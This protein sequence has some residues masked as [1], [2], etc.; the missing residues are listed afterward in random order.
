M[1]EKTCATCEHF[2][3]HYTLKSGR[4][5]RIYCGHCTVA[6]PKTKRPT[7]RACEKYAYGHPDESAFAS[8]KYLTKEMVKYL[9]GMELL[10]TIEDDPSF[11]D[12]L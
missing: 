9:F 12:A 3:Q 4:L 8:K 2:H 1:S 11:S 5:M 6:S 7:T 10:P